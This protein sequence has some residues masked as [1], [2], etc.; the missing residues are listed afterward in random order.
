MRLPCFRGRSGNN[1]FKGSVNISAP[2]KI[3]SLH[4]IKR[5]HAPFSSNHAPQ[6]FRKRP[7]YHQERERDPQTPGIA[8]APQ[9]EEII[10][11]LGSIVGEDRLFRCTGF[12]TSE[13][14]FRILCGQVSLTFFCMIWSCRRNNI[15]FNLIRTW[16]NLLVIY[17]GSAPYHPDRSQ[18]KFGDFLKVSS[19]SDA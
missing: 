19:I 7:E 17:H 5:R 16:G 10:L 11:F 2:I 4:K 12:L 3:P 9:K 15:R 6:L 13:K 18:H 1:I 8:T 14:A